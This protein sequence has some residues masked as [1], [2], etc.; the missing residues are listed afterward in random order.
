MKYFLRRLLV[1]FARYEPYDNPEAV[2]GWSGWYE[3]AG[4]CIAFRD[5]DGGLFTRW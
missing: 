1:P 2:G 3:I 4:R 5:V